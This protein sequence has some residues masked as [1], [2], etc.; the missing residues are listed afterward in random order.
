[1]RMGRS[2]TR[3]TLLKRN[4]ISPL[5]SDQSITE[6]AVAFDGIQ[7]LPMKATRQIRPELLWRHIWRR[8]KQGGRERGEEESGRERER[9]REGERVPREAPNCGFHHPRLSV[10]IPFQVWGWAGRG[11]LTPPGLLTGGPW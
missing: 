8:W 4:T 5:N 9:E 6:L 11:L 10:E 1:M 2:R 3:H 7:I